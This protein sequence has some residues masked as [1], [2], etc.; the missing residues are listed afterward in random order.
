MDDE[1]QKNVDQ[2]DKGQNEDDAN[3]ALVDLRDESITKTKVENSSKNNTGEVEEKR[4][5]R[6][7]KQKSTRKIEG[8]T[9]S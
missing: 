9:E 6:I 8:E 4:D 3:R 7:L 1:D 2:N 5:T